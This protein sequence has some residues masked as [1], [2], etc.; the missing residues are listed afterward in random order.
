ML[1]HVPLQPPLSLL[2]NLTCN[3]AI[4]NKSNPLDFNIS[5]VNIFPLTNIPINF[6]F[7]LNF[8]GT[9]CAKPQNPDLK[10]PEVVS[11]KHSFVWR[12]LE[13]CVQI[14]EMLDSHWFLLFPLD[15]MKTYWIVIYYWEHQLQHRKITFCENQ[16]KKSFFSGYLLDGMHS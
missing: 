10:N 6:I 4:F 12:S 1:I 11:E 5:I 3:M 16:R 13:E 14:M 8:S 2:S 9:S 7:Y 15:P